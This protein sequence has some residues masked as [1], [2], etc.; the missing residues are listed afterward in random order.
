LHPYRSFAWKC[1]LFSLRDAPDFWCLTL[2]LPNSTPIT[3]S[4]S[5]LFMYASLRFVKLPIIE[6]DDDVILAIVVKSQTHSFRHF[7][8]YKT[9]IT[10]VV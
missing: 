7:D 5:V 6:H 1:T 3:L 2:R 8:K 9:A 10:T 4:V